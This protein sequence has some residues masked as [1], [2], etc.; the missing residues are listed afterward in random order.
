M[1]CKPSN[2]ISFFKLRTI[3]IL[4]LTS[5][6]IKYQF[7]TCVIIWYLFFTGVRVRF[8]F[9]FTFATTFFYMCENF[10]LVFGF[11]NDSSHL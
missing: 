3:T 8:H 1:H 11:G 4:Q 7:V 2:L 10:S 5:V 9:F 6:K